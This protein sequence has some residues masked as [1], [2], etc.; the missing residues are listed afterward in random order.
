MTIQSFQTNCGFL[1]DQGELPL[2]QKAAIHA[3]LWDVMILI[4]ITIT[5]M[6]TFTFN[7]SIV[8]F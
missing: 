3:V 7:G 5:V 1:A 6:I 2:A 4:T 8:L